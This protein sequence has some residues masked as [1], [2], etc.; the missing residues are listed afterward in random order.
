M[1]WSDPI[2]LSYLGP[3][4]DQV[5]GLAAPGQRI[6]DPLPQLDRS[7]RTSRGGLPTRWA[8]LGARH[9]G[10]SAVSQLSAVSSP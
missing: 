5:T 10:L 3:S 2:V 6:R 1:A 7:G 4:W 9:R 8:P